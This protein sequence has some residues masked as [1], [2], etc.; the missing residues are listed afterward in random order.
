MNHKAGVRMNSEFKSE[1]W[2]SSSRTMAATVTYNGLGSKL[3]TSLSQQCI[4]ELC[5]TMKC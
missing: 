2:K 5:V 3:S 1:I 4:Y